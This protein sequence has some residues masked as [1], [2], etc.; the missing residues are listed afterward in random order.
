MLIDYSLA[1]IFLPVIL[2][3]IAPLWAGLITVG[4]YGTHID[5]L[6]LL[7]RGLRSLF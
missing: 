4:C 2:F 3:I 1:I 6:H 5:H 7:R